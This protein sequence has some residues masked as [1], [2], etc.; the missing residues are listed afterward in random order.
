MS[1]KK[2]INDETETNYSKFEKN[3]KA[4][5]KKNKGE[6]DEVLLLSKLYYLNKTSQFNVL[7][8]IFGEQ[9]SKGIQILNMNT[10]SEIENINEIS[11]ASSCFKADC[12][13]KMKQTGKIWN[14]SIKSNNCA[15]AAIL[16]HTPRSAKIF[17]TG[18][19]SS[20]L[21]YLDEVINEYNYKRT[22]K[23]V[24]QD[25]VI[26]KFES[27]E[28]DNIL[29]EQ[30]KFVLRYFVFDGT[31]KGYSKCRA[32]S[33]MVYENENITFIE[34][35]NENKQKKYIDSIYDRIVL[36]LRHKGMPDQRRKTDFENCKPW[37]FKDVKSD[38]T[39]KL[40]GSL[41]I[42]IK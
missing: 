28:T 4:N 34:C 36:S 19:L 38:G 11:K 20:T 29:K 22:N 6:K 33:I 37:I 40:K 1:L 39:I 18:I 32:N 26:N 7:T 25:M 16:N 21:P 14:S 15:N 8:S 35:D 23:I 27:L 5:N 10:S 9:A 17:Q 41:H 13:M 30:F 3:T 42:R 2:P 31:G 12:C 24:G